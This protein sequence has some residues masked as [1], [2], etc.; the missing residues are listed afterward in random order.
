MVD[1]ERQRQEMVETQLFPRGITDQRV[2]DAFR[3]VPRH[4]FVPEDVRQSAYDDSAL[5]IGAGQTISQPFMVAI[6]TELLRLKATEQ[7]LEVGTGSGYQTAIL[8]ELCRRVY[9]IERV[10]PLS[11]Q[12]RKITGELGYQ[13][14]EF[15]HGDGSEGYAPGAPYDGIMVTAGCPN[16]PAPLTDQ[17][18]DGGRLVLPV[19][20]KHFQTLLL[21]TKEKGEL[22]IE[23]SIGCV[24]VPLIGKYGWPSPPP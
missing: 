11:D 16:I 20:E 10:A 4:L 12:A 7:V 21:I 19:G 1:P 6:M 9:T 14:I 24:F 17:L 23:P 22:K 3:R 18:A 2:L 15:V 13:S 5:P 8:A